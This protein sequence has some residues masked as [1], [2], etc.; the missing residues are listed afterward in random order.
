MKYVVQWTGRDGASGAQSEEDAKR[1]LQLVSKWSPAPDATFH[2]FV[3]RLDGEG[4]YAVVETDNPLA[5]M[6]G[7]AKFGTHLKFTV[8]PVVDIMESVQVGQDA[9]EFRD[10]IS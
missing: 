7:P 1:V 4:G 10:S 3:A 5:V 2:Q 6:E 9:I 8:E